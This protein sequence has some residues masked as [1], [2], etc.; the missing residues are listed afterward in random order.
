MPNRL[1]EIQVNLRC[2]HVRRLG[3]PCDLE[4]GGW[5]SCYCAMV[6]AKEKDSKKADL[7]EAHS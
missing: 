1:A 6:E 4:G 5:L 2:D 7:P 3:E